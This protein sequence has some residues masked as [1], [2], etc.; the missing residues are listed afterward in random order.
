VDVT[1]LTGSVCSLDAPFT[2]TFSSAPITG[3]IT[4]TPSGPSGGTYAGMGDV[5]GIGSISWSGG[6]TLT[7]RD[8]ESPSVDG[9]DGTTKLI[10][11]I[12]QEAPNFWGG[13]G[14]DFPLIP[15]ASA[16]P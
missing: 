10:G 6:Y 12:T 16:C 5:G 3:T 7:G 11:P 4:F 2:L 8:T 14:P 1:G 13:A 15:D 9:D